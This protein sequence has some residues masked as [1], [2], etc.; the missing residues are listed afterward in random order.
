MATNDQ[1]RALVRSHGDG[2]DA[3]FYAVAVQVAAKAARAGQSR[4]AQELRDLVDGFRASSTVQRGV[5][6]VVPVARPRGELAGLLSATYP[7]DRLAD[8]TLAP[9]L[10]AA[11]ERV[12]TEQRQ[13]SFLGEY[14]LFP[15]RRVLMTGPPGTGKTSTARAV[16]GELGL[17]LFAVRLDAL[18][19]KYMGETAAKLRLVFDQLSEAHGVYLFDEVDA[20][21]S[22]R[23]LGNDV[24]EIRRVIS[25]FLQFLEEDPSDSIVMAASNHPALLDRAF[26]RRFDITLD[27]DLP[28]D[29]GV[30]ELI[31][32][33]LARIRTS[34]LGWSRIMAAARGLSHAEIVIG[35]QNAAKQALLSG[36]SKVLTEDLVVALSER[37]R[38]AREE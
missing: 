27:F 4:F 20:L 37:Q 30:R 24:G 8:L 22:E 32:E 6:T 12:L 23:S 26:F 17:P 18:I 19:T 21:A 31:G 9:P 7:D 25:S 5:A 14:G 38:S 2:D 33:R 28:D 35:A 34:N 1:V 29:A 10:R 15:A 13:R 16:A 11:I 36:R 3:Q